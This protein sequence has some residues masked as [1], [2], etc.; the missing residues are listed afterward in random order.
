MARKD[1]DP[2]F[3]NDSNPDTCLR[4]H[5]LLSVLLEEN[6]Q[7]DPKFGC[8]AALVKYRPLHAA[9]DILATTFKAALSEAHAYIKRACILIGHTLPYEL[10]HE[11]AVDM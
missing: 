6:V 7:P 8:W 5:T 2:W 1:R 4:G 3:D 11:D 9:S 10:E